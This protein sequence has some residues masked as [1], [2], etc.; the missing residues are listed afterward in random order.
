MKIHIIILSFIF[1]FFSYGCT[2]KTVTKA[3]SVDEDYVLVEFASK[4][5]EDFHKINNMP[6]EIDEINQL[7]GH[8]P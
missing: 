4:L 1:I 5:E 3:S 7:N 6:T 8:H 2:Q